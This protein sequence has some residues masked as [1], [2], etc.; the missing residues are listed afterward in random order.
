MNKQ[1]FQLVREP[2]DSIRSVV[3]RWSFQRVG[4]PF[5]GCHGGEVDVSVEKVAGRLANDEVAGDIFVFGATKTVSNTLN[6]PKEAREDSRSSVVDGFESR[7]IREI[8]KACG[9]RK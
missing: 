9:V 1:R 6:W 5:Y 7:H 4:D 8:P 3:Q 2:D